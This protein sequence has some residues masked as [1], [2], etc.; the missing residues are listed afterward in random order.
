MVAG[1]S[2]ARR[3]QVVRVERESDGA[4]VC[5][6]CE[7]ADGFWT[8]FRGLMLR[9]GLGA[10]EGM[11]IRPAGSVHTLFMRFPLDCVFLDGDLEVVGVRAGVR[12]WRAAAA[13][14]AKATLELPAGAAGRAG[15]DVGDRL[16]VVAE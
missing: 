1:G 16:R 5:E 13:R 14:G 9:R 4:V 15:L 11:L 6:R 10:G 8:R 7:V 12:P 3:V 2:E